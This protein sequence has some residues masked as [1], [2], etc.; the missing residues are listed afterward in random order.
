MGL[1][2]R[3][4]PEPLAKPSFVLARSDG[5]PYDFVRETDDKVALLFFGYTNCPDVCPLHMANIAAVL[6]KMP[7]EDRNAIRV[8]F[9]TTDPERDTPERLRDWLSGFDP[10][11]I[12]LHG[13]RASVAAVERS[14]GLAP[15]ARASDTGTYAVNHAAQVIAFG[16][17]NVA[18]VVYPFGTRQEDWAHDL[19]R[20]VRHAP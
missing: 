7:W 1:R 13:E 15:A 9:V 19:P 2:G 10:S 14:L 5:T 16:R 11:F 3:P 12:G 20:L 6:K 17:D 4:L 18:R 8:V